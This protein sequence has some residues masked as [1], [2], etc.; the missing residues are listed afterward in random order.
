MNDFDKNLKNAICKDIT[1]SSSYEKNIQDTIDKCIISKNK[2]QRV[3]KSKIKN[4]FFKYIIESAAI[5]TLSILGLTVYAISTEK[6]NLDF[7]NIGWIKV[8]KNYVENATLVEQ[9]IETDTLSI[10][11][12]SVSGD[13]AYLI[14]QYKLR[15]TEKG[16]EKIGVPEY[17]EITGY[18]LNLNQRIFI[19]DNIKYADIYMNQISDVE[20]QIIEMIDITDI[21]EKEF[22]IVIWLDNVQYI[23]H[24]DEETRISNYG[25]EYINK[26][27]KAR[28]KLN[29]NNNFKPIER[30]INENQKLIISNVGNTQYGNYISGKIVTEGLTYKEYIDTYVRNI[31]SFIVTDSNGE[32]LSINFNSTE[33]MKKLYKLNSNGDYDICNDRQ[34][35]EEKDI[36]KIEQNYNIF[37]EDVK[38]L[39]KIKVYMISGY[40]SGDFSDKFENATWYPLV[41]SEAPYTIPSKFG[42]NVKITKIVIDEE[43][44]SFYYETEGM[45]NIP[46]GITLRDKTK[47]YCNTYPTE[48]QIIKGINGDE[49]IEKFAINKKFRVGSSYFPRDISDCMDNIE[50]AIYDNIDYEIDGESIDIEMPV[51]D[52]NINEFKDFEIVDVAECL[53]KGSAPYKE[54]DSTYNCIIHVA[55]DKFDNLL[56]LDICEE[57]YYNLYISDQI[58]FNA[59]YCSHKFS[60]FK[61]N[62]KEYFE[63]YDGTYSE[64]YIENN[65]MP[66]K[67]NIYI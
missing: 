42:G 13:N 5:F 15:L 2:V 61:N 46:I 32:S 28:V 20:Y 1:L 24:T 22:D 11:L 9:K 17:D 12:E 47:K 38:E 40:N 18:A 25:Y 29:G 53:I 31:K 51:Q 36:I 33:D 14:F 23:E 44:V 35:D 63:K 16:F 60:T 66:W 43:N 26:E 52:K 59:G 48:K 58:V 64:E 39:S 4:I 30:K 10:E 7:S 3:K 45:V 27:I 37:L 19:N 6:I 50:F 49:N 56:K 8:E 54:Y 55:Y 21:K 65:S 34:I 62:L 41:N 67:Y 57:K